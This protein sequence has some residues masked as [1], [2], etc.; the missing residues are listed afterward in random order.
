MQWKAPLHLRVFCLVLDWTEP[1]AQSLLSR[2]E[3]L[4]YKVKIIYSM[5][6]ISN[7]LF[8]ERKTITD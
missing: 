7:L 1:V 8:L 4:G 3:E 5:T 2:L 6:K